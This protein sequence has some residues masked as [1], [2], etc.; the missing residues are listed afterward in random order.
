[1]ADSHFSISNLD[2]L[3]LL[4]APLLLQPTQTNL[5]YQC[6]AHSRAP[7]GAPPPLLFSSQQWNL[8]AMLPFLGKYYPPLSQCPSFSL[9]GLLKISSLVNSFGQGFMT[10]CLDNDK[11]FTPPL[12]VHPFFQSTPV[13]QLLIMPLSCLWHGTSWALMLLYMKCLPQPFFH[14]LLSHPCLFLP[15]P[16]TLHPSSFYS[17]V[18]TSKVSP[19]LLYSSSGEKFSFSAF[20][21]ILIFRT[22]ILLGERP[23]TLLNF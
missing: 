23:S 12:F 11:N 18:A 17:W 19:T 3:L 5:L 8:G 6:H 22:R 9:K 16:K 2:P 13:T 15:P 1:M 10:S 21:E 7:Q 14:Y 4:D 20:I